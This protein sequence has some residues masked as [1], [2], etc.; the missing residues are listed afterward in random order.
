MKMVVCSW[1]ANPSWWQISGSYVR[2]YGFTLV[3]PWAQI[4]RRS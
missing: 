3:E 4:H 1:N 2:V